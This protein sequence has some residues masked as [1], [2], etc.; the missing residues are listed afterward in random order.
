M[1]NSE[2]NHYGFSIYVYVFSREFT[3]YGSLKI[4]S[5]NASLVTN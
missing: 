5:T 1:Y 2:Y 4:S 3:H